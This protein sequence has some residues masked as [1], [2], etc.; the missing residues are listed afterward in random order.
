[1]V[2]DLFHCTFASALD[3][4]V[5]E[6]EQAGSEV[7]VIASGWLIW[8]WGL[9]Y[10][11]IW[12]DE[13]SWPRLKNWFLSIQFFPVSY[14]QP[15]WLIH[16]PVWNRLFCMFPAWDGTFPDLIAFRILL[17]WDCCQE[18]Q[19]Y[20]GFLLN[21]FLELA[22]YPFWR[23]FWIKFYIIRPLGMV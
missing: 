9:R 18:I 3:D 10:C 22:K 19:F 6:I 8:Q 2:D 1:M 11:I 20:S 16:Y 12:C 13:K 23:I 7:K 5:N 17:V 4:L 14:R 15:I 21:P